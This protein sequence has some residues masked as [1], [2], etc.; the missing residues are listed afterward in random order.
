[1]YANT[2]SEL[3]VLILGFPPLILRIKM[4]T[5][6]PFFSGMYIAT[7]NKMK[8]SE[9]EDIFGSE[10]SFHEIE[11]PEPELD[12]TLINKMSGGKFLDASR[13]VAKEKAIA[14]FEILQEPVVVEAVSLFVQCL[15]GYPGPFIGSFEGEYAL[16]IVVNQI[17]ASRESSNDKATAYAT[18]AVWYPKLKKAEYRHA[19]IEGKVSLEQVGTNGFGWD[20]IFIPKVNG[21]DVKITFA[22]MKAGCKNLIS[23]RR[24]VAEKVQQKPFTSPQ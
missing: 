15:D 22:Q 4:E 8:V 2:W 19:C 6:N 11:L 20:P 12:P 16:N 10:V 21:V 24:V 7:G 14:A 1:M 17:K 13:K 3:K 5:I 18:L 9:Y 23:M